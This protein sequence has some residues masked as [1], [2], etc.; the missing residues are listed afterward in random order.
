ME[1]IDS[2]YFYGH[3]NLYG[4]MRNFYPSVFYD[5]DGIRFCSSEQFFMY[6]KAKTFD[7]SNVELINLIL[8]E[9]NPGKIKQYGRR[10]KN[11]DENYWNIVRYDVMK[12][13]L[14]L[15]FT[16]NPVLKDLLLKTESKTLYEASPYDKIWGIG[17]NIQTALVTD[18]KH[19]GNNL[20]GNALMD[21]RSL[22]K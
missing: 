1:T 6:I 8:N 22:L 10:V 3:N 5:T 18:K 20:L 19:Y 14:A 15:K 2:I 7:S 9:T 16:Q 17:L 4:W 11:Y 12:Y 21:I 13:G